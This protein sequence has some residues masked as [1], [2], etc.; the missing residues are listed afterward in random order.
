MQD[1]QYD[2]G[3]EPN[4]PCCPIVAMRLQATEKQFS[5]VSK[6][7]ENIPTPNNHVKALG[8]LDFAAQAEIVGVQVGTD[9]HGMNR[10][11]PGWVRSFFVPFVV[12]RY[13]SP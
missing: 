11:G 2:S 7:S 13:S 5:V 3:L 10:G 6:M 12:P 9:E 8:F 4:L 1:V